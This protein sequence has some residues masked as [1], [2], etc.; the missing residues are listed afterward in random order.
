MEKVV[1]ND[2]WQEMFNEMNDTYATD[3]DTKIDNGIDENT[4]KPITK[5]LIH[6][7]I[8]SH[9]IYDLQNNQ[10]NIAPAEVYMPL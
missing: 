4:E 10:I 9:S 7:F 1:I 8:D 5:T 2:K 3:I 6:G